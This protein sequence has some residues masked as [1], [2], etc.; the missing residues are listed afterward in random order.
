MFWLI[1]RTNKNPL[2]EPMVKC[3][4]VG[5]SYTPTDPNKIVSCPLD[6]CVFSA[7]NLRDQQLYSVL[8]QALKVKKQPAVMAHANWMN[9]KEK[10]KAALMRTGLWLAKKEVAG[11]F[12][13]GNGVDREIGT[14]GNWTCRPPTG[15]LFKLNY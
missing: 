12:Q 7:S 13:E 4:A 14:A 6:N 10:K 3:P 1:L 2:P 5:E 9:G 11:G 8:Q 15:E